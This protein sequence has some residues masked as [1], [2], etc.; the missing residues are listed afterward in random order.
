MNRDNTGSVLED[1]SSSSR[2]TCAWKRIAKTALWRR[3]ANRFRNGDQGFFLY[4]G[5]GHM[6]FGELPRLRQ[7][8]AETG[9]S[10]VLSWS[11][12]IRRIASGSA[13]YT[14][15]ARGC[16]FRIRIRDIDCDYRL[17]RREILERVRLT[18]T[19][20]TIWVELVRNLELT[21]AQW[22]RSGSILPRCTGRRNFPH[23]APLA[24]TFR[25]IAAAVDQAGDLQ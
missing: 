14:I 4:D 10:T 12:T 13:M 1:L 20:G 15:F 19:S 6:T 9:W 2:P 24:V 5:D 18:C 16:S 25:A 23:C 3:A 17:I 22:R 7:G 21:A 11:C 8:D